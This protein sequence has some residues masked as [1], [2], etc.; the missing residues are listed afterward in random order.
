MAQRFTA[1]RMARLVARWRESN[2]SGAGFAR[3]HGVRPWTF[4]YWSRTVSAARSAHPSPPTFVPMHVTPAVEMG[5][6][7]VVLVGG[8]RLHV[9]AGAS[10][11]LVRAVVVALRPPC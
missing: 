2:E 3:R 10:A 7:E 1:A 8:D 6:I 11:D 4:W 5:R 9:Q